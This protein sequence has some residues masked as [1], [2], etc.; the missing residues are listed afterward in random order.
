MATAIIKAILIL[1]IFLVTVF[2]INTIAENGRVVQVS[3]V[4]TKS[5][6]TPAATIAIAIITV[7]FD[8]AMIYL[9]MVV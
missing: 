8:S 5:Y 7:A 3:E 4:V 2:G 1:A 6:L 9:F